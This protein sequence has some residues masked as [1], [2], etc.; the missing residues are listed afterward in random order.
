MIIEDLS[1][2]SIKVV[3]LPHHCLTMPGLVDPT[4]VIYIEFIIILIY[5]QVKNSSF[6]LIS[7]NS[8]FISEARGNF[9]LF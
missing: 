2:P 4:L 3:V 6:Y 7:A 9:V 8:C 5:F 1:C